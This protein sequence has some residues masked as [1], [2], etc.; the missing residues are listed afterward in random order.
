MRLTGCQLLLL[1]A[2]SEQTQDICALELIYSTINWRNSFVVGPQSELSAGSLLWMGRKNQ[3]LGGARYKCL[4][5]K[6]I[7]LSCLIIYVHLTSV[8]LSGIFI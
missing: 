7:N 8:I 4:A 6:Q 2:V 5:F 1:D 3:M